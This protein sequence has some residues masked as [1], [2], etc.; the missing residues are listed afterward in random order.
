M[1]RFSGRTGDEI[2][3]RL[4]E[5]VDV[6]PAERGPND[7]RLIECDGDVL[8]EREPK[9]QPASACEDGGED[10]GAHALAERARNRA[11]ADGGAAA[12]VVCPGARSGADC[13]RPTGPACHRVCH[14]SA[15][16]RA[17]KDPRA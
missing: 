2:E 9:A 1:A 12:V 16:S 3:W 17:R 4:I 13:R 6:A 7:G 14:V 11:G 10:P 8:T 15:F 5:N